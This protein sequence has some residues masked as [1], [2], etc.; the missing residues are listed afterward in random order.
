[1]IRVACTW[2]LVAL[3]ASPFTAPFSS[4]DLTVLLGR[5]AVVQMAPFARSGAQMTAALGSTDSSSDAYCVS[6]LVTRTELGRNAPFRSPGLLTCASAA[7][8]AAAPLHASQSRYGPST[9]AA[10]LRL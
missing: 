2:I 10:V 4:C 6:P 1:M 3:A 5:T 7:T 9:R 8:A